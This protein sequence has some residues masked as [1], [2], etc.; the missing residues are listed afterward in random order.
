MTMNTGRKFFKFLTMLTLAVIAPATVNTSPIP[1]PEEVL[2]FGDSIT[3]HHTDDP[4]DN[5][6]GWWSI[7]AAQR[8]L[9]PYVSAQGGGAILKPGFGC[10]GT[11]IR[12]RFEETVERV[13]PDE[14]WIASGRNET[15]VCI[16]GSAVPVNAGFRTSALDSFF[17]FAGQVADA[18]GIPRSRVYLTT[19]W[20]TVNSTQRS[21]IVM[22]MVQARDHGLRF[23]NIPRLDDTLTR[24]GTHPNR[25]GSEYIAAT[26]AADMP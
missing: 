3:S 9:T 24:D 21:A 19:P 23:I 18:N 6:Q 11:G 12:D 17:E 14:I 22:D 7:L 13:Q 15:S 8:N 10:Y 1:R 25:A 20:G 16:N 5:M 26:L 4:G 2:I